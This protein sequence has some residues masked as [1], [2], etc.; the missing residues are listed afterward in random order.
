MKIKKK[1]DILII[2]RTY[3]SEVVGGIATHVGY[4]TD[5]L[6]KIT[7]T[8]MSKRKICNVHVFTTWDRKDRH[9]GGTPPNL[10]IHWFPGVGGHFTSVGD[11]PYEEVVEYGFNHWW[12]IKPDIIHAHDFESVLIGLMFKTA[13]KV[14][15]VMTVH[16]APK[17]WDPTLPQRDVK[18]NLLQTLLNHSIVDKFVAPSNAY[19]RSLLDRNCPEERVKKIP[20]GIP[21]GKLL[22]SPNKPG[23]TQRLNLEDSHELILCPSRLDPHKGIETFIDAAKM[24]KKALP[25]RN[26]IFA[27]AGGSGPTWYRNKLEQQTRNLSLG[28]I[29]R[30]GTSKHE[31]LHLAEMPTLYRR[32]KI[33]VLPSQREGFGQALIEAYVYKKPVVGSTTGGIPEVVIPNETGLLFKRNEAKDLAFQITRLLKDNNLALLLAQQ[34]YK[35][36]RL[37]YD[38]GVMAQRYFRLYKKVAGVTIK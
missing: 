11:V 14:P 25:H 2:S 38:I 31:D 17:D 27:V 4:L 37:E 33:C 34:A 20:H 35:R 5:G 19:K 30:L 3:S 29:I 32:A 26:L 18:D 13:F 36:V 1:L 6:H 24:V 12:K 15:L 28:T 22:K 8:R 23:V 21:V 7:K 10:M 9:Q 16:K